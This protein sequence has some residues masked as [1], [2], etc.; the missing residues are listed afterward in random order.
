MGKKLIDKIHKIG[1]RDWIWWKNV[2]QSFV[3]FFF[4]KDLKKEET[5][6]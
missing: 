2:N 5:M 6:G 3:F 4:D 1:E